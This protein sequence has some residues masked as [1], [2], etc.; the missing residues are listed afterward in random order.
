M[1]L[2]ERK[3]S[4][5]KELKELM[6]KYN[7]GFEVDDSMQNHSFRETIYL[8]LMPINDFNGYPSSGSFELGRILNQY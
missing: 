8:V 6:T 4:F 7:A 2:E 5:L 1:S 3:E